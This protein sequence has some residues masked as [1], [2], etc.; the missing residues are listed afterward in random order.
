[1]TQSLQF[2]QVERQFRP[3][4][5]YYYYYCLYQPLCMILYKSCQKFCLQVI[6]IKKTC[7]I[8]SYKNASNATCSHHANAVYW[9]YTR[10]KQ[11]LDLYHHVN[12]RLDIIIASR[13]QTVKSGSGWKQKSTLEENSSVDSWIKIYTQKRVATKAPERAET[14][15][16]CDQAAFSGTASLLMN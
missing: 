11:K 4:C 16:W 15:A 14:G 3:S 6:T 8:N 5:Y 10:T 9:I 12:K 7:C 1:M 2:A 13:T